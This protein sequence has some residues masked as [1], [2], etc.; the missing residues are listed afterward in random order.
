MDEVF[1]IAS[2]QCERCRGKDPAALF[3]KAV[4]DCHR[5]L[6]GKRKVKMLMWGDRLLD[7]KQMKY[8]EWEAS[9]NG[10]APAVDL[11]PKDIIICDWHY[12]LR[13]AYPS[14]PYFQRKGF[15]VWPASWRQ[16]QAAVALLEYSRKNASERMIGHLC[17]TWSGADQVARVLLGEDA[18]SLKG[19]K[20]I[21]SALRLCLEKLQETK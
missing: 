18:P 16:S 3:A 12:E 7:D 9:R 19:A 1:L 13:E 5:H 14:V 6:V 2:E 8:G 20:E 17:T 15:R 10:T 11:I 21:V 4:N